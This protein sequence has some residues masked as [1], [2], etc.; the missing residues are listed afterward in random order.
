HRLLGLRD[1]ELVYARPIERQVRAR[2]AADLQHAPADAAEQ[3]SAAIPEHRLL[4]AG[5]EPVVAGGEDAPVEAH[6]A[7]G[8]MTVNDA[9]WGPGLPAKRPIAM[10]IGSNATFAPT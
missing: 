6:D 4:G 10:S 8:S 9:P 7:A 5:H 1:D 3:R 2:A